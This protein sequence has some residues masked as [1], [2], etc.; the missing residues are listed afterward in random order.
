MVA[1]Q[2]SS[3]DG[4]GGKHVVALP[5][6]GISCWCA[7][8]IACLG[9]GVGGSSALFHLPDKAVGSHGLW[10]VPTMSLR[11]PRGLGMVIRV[12]FVFGPAGSHNINFY[13][14][15]GRC[16]QENLC[17]WLN[18]V[19]AAVGGKGPSFCV[20]FFFSSVCCSSLFSLFFFFLMGLSTP[21]TSSFT[22]HSCLWA[23]FFPT[24]LFGDILSA[25]VSR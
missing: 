24:G 4:I 9:R 20:V 11:F 18:D 8:L 16:H 22:S 5:Y 6:S 1:P 3:A 12:V 2:P 13:I 19:G 17:S 14:R 10:G 15:R 21:N 25:S 23:R 7:N